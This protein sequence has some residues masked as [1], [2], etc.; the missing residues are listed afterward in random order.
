MRRK[1]PTDLGRAVVSFFQ[2]HLPQQRGLSTHSI[3]SY[4]DAVVLWLQF[5]ADDGQ[6]GIEKLNLSDLTVERA[7]RFLEYLEVK[8]RNGIATRNARLAA[9]HTFARYLS[10]QYPER[11]GE[12]QGI[13]G[14][15][16]KRGARQAP[17]EYLE[18]ADIEA[19]LGRIDQR[20]VAG[21]RDYA[22]FA[23]MFNTG[24]RVQEV[25]NL[26]VSDV[27]VDPPEQVR[28]H[29]KGNKIRLC[30]LWPKTATLLRGLMESKSEASGCRADAYVFVNRSGDSL[31]RFGVRYL[32]R[33]YLPD[34]LSPALRRRIHPHSLR[35]TTAVHLLKS[36][37]DFGTISQWLGHAGLQ[38]TMRYARAD[39]AL[40]RQALAQVFP[41]ALGAPK[42]GGM[43]LHGTELTRWLRRL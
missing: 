25:L 18:S 7:E 31:T 9:L 43:T 17:I 2:D 15:P 4:R 29:G 23:L 26:R 41:D 5:V 37:V 6:R 24:A 10:T 20:T 21:Q 42:A 14:I 33:K 11:L 8:R 16:F 1:G 35:H 30:P 40:K 32:L 13:L 34:Y 39:L 19:L 38:T 36:G 12:F 22:L 27:R 3:K 28:L